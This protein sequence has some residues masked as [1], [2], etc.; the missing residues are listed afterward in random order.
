VIT[1][2]N[3]DLIVTGNLSVDDG[4]GGIIVS[5]VKRVAIANN[6]PDRTGNGI[7]VYTPASEVLVA[8]NQV[9][10]SPFSAFGSTETRS[11]AA[12]IRRADEHRRRGNTVRHA[13]TA[14]PRTAF[15]LT[16]RSQHGRRKS[17]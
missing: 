4:I 17:H 12:P 9:D 7:A 14:A 11:V 6:K 16:G 3:R 1:A 13:G 5:N 15:S 8:R 10:D 2:P